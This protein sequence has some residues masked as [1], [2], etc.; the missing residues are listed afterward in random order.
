MNHHLFGPSGLVEEAV[1]E[2]SEGP[3]REGQLKG[4]GSSENGGRG[5][6]G[7]LPG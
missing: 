3:K 7:G 4:W 1:K 5:D 6:Q 2:E